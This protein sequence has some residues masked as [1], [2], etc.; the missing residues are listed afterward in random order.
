[1]NRKSGVVVALFSYVCLFFAVSAA[2]SAAS[3]VSPPASS[4]RPA[5]ILVLACG[6]CAILLHRYLRR[7]EERKLY[8]RIAERFHK[9]QQMR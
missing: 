6:A 4:P 1:V 5:S 8:A 7:T 9:R 2:A 3:L